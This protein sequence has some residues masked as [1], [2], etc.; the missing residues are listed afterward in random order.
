MR[1]TNGAKAIT[2]SRIASSVTPISMPPARYCVAPEASVGRATPLLRTFAQKLR[3][4][5]VRGAIARAFAILE[6][7]G[8]HGIFAR[9]RHWKRA[10]IAPYR[11]PAW[12]L[13]HG[14]TVITS[15]GVN[16]VGHPYGALGMGEHIRKSA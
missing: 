14:P 3:V 12:P 2:S 1:G 5:G 8:M 16:L 10:G 13:R 4:L 7:D 15:G 11:A 6:R 9:A